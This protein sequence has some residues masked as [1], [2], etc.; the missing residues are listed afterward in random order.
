M[1]ALREIYRALAEDARREPS[2]RRPNGCSTTSTSSRPPR[3]TSCAICRPSF[4]RRLPRVAADEFAGLPRIYALALEL[5]RSER[6][7]A[8]CAA[9][10]AI[11]HRLSVGDAADDRRA[12]GVAE[13]AEARAG[14]APAR[15][16]PTCSRRRARIGST[17]IALPRRSRRSPQA[18]GDWPAERSSGLRHPPAAALARVRRDTRRVCATSSTRVGGA[19]SD[20]RRRDPRRR[21]AP[22]RASRRRWPT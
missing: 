21:A 2:R 14:R 12:L 19:R 13:R 9:A 7:P 3:A 10:A 15:E 20:G 5:I 1:Q 16:W 18:F 8:R 11:H 17:P 6:R 4:F 22:G